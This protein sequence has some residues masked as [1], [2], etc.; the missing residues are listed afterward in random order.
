MRL[1]VAMRNHQV[2]DVRNPRESISEN[3][4]GIPSIQSIGE[5]QQRPRQ[6][7]PP[8]TRR[9]DDFFLFFSRIPLDKKSGKENNVAQ[10]ADDFHEMPFDAEE[11]AVVPDQVVEPIHSAGKI[12]ERK[13]GGK[14]QNLEVSRLSRDCPESFPPFV[15][16][17]RDFRARLEERFCRER[18]G[19]LRP[20]IN[21]QEIVPVRRHRGPEQQRRL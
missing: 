5:Q 3:E 19:A 18:R 14:R 16:L 6:T 7:Q 4:N 2:A 11:V 13:P 9:H 20:P 15:P 8:E 12:A 21:R 17:L 1:V 10:P